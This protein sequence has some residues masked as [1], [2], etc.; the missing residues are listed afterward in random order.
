MSD[1]YNEIALAKAEDVLDEEKNREFTLKAL[2]E[3]NR[4]RA[5]E[6]E[7]AQGRSNFQIEILKNPFKRD[8]HANLTLPDIV[9]EAN[10]ILKSKNIISFNLSENIKKDMYLYQ[11]IIEFNYPI[12]FSENSKFFITPF[13]ENKKNCEKISEKKL[14]SLYKCK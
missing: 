5:S 9:I 14:V 12:K 4:W 6:V 8:S 7:L 10:Q 3:C 11:R 13:E 2:A 1:N